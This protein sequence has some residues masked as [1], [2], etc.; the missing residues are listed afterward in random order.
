VID[1][2]FTVKNF[3]NS[4]G[5]SKGMK[6]SR[7]ND[8]SA[9][10]LPYLIVYRT[11]TTID[12]FDHSWQDTVGTVSFAV[13]MVAT[14]RDCDARHRSFEGS[15]VFLALLLP[16]MVRTTD[17]VQCGRISLATSKVL[18]NGRPWIKFGTTYHQYACARSFCVHTSTE[19]M[20]FTSSS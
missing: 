1:A 17:N 10:R 12:Y 7:H 11:T 20:S 8:R 6:S 9:H 18:K 19:C 13:H 2:V 14:D 5:Y 16:W 15:F 3:N 4:N